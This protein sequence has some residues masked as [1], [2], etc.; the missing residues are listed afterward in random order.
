MERKVM[1][2]LYKE[3]ELAFSLYFLSDWTQ[4]RVT[5]DEKAERPFLTKCECVACVSSEIV[6]IHGE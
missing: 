5:T 4:L 3:K 6:C 2:Y 1:G